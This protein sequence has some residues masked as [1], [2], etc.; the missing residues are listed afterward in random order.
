L[1]F[2]PADPQTFDFAAPGDA[3]C[4]IVDHFL[5]D[6]AEDYAR[7][8]LALREDFDATKIE[9]DDPFYPLIEICRSESLLS[10][11]RLQNFP[12]SIPEGQIALERMTWVEAGEVWIQKWLA[13]VVCQNSFTRRQP[14]LGI[15]H[16]RGRADDSD[17]DIRKR[18]PW[19]TYEAVRP[20][21]PQA[22]LWIDVPV[23]PTKGQEWFT[24]NP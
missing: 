21:K 5:R 12:P 8:G 14:L 24:D 6:T 16:H 17:Y 20:I 10:I 1:T 4:A 9:T 19:L 2:C 15:G 11:A 22:G 23:A 13:P 3:H 18:W 7:A